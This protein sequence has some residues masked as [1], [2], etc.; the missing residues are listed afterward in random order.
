MPKHSGRIDDVSHAKTPWLYGWRTRRR[1]MELSRQIKLHNMRPPNVK[2][3]DH[4][5][6]HKVL[7]PLFLIVALKFVE[8]TLGWWPEHLP[9]RCPPYR[10]PYGVQLMG[11][12]HLCSHD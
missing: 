2:V 10:C 6:H 9:S 1:D 8:N 12:L 5:L 11:N 4:Q 7:S 3:I